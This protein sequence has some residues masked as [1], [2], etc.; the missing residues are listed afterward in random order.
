MKQQ[1][2]CEWRRSTMVSDGDWERAR[3]GG[4]GG[5]ASCG[6]EATMAGG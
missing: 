5:T 2:L 6:R 4:V 3:V 1:E